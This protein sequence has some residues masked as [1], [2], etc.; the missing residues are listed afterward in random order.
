M[1]HFLFDLCLYNSFHI[2]V[3]WHAVGLHCD[4][5][6]II[7]GA[8]LSSAPAAFP[9]RGRFYKLSHRPARLCLWRLS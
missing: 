5:S 6:F 4:L 7:D 9:V 3:F 1:L 8:M 2:N